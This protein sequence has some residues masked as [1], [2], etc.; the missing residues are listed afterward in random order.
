MNLNTFSITAAVMATLMGSSLDPCLHSM[1]VL[2]GASLLVTLFSVVYLAAFGP[3]LRP[4]YRSLTLRTALGVVFFDL[5]TDSLNALALILPLSLTAH[6]I[7][8]ESQIIFSLVFG[9]CLQSTRFKASDIIGAG[10]QLVAA[11]IQAAGERRTRK[12]E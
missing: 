10:H 8:G 1:T 7:I 4:A 12:Q 5:G 9:Y 3:G 11:R 6:S 2:M